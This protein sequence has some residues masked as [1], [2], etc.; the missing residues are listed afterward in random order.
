MG[1]GNIIVRFLF[2]TDSHLSGKVPRHRLDDFPTTMTGKLREVYQTAVEKACDFVAFGGDFFNTHR[3][4]NYD[5]I[6]D[7]M[8]IV[9]E[10]PLK[11]Y[12]CIGE[13]DLYGHNL[14]SYRTSTLRF[15]VRRCP[16][17]EIIRDPI[18]LGEVVLY[19]KHE[20][21]KMEDAIKQEV[22]SSK[23]NILV[24][25]ELI[26]NQ[27][28]MFD[29]ISTASL[30]G[31]PFD[32]VVS[33]DLHDGYDTH[34]ANDTWFVNPGSLAR[35]STAD[36]HRWPQVAIIEI[37]KGIPPMVDIQRLKCALPGDEVLGESIAEVARARED[38]DDKADGFTEEM[39]Q[40]EAESVDVHDLIQKVGRAKGL[41]EVVLNYLATKRAEAA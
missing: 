39:L 24:C 35:R 32:L 7:A 19:S 3:L 40:F 8:D 28:P 21:E 29:I 10:C 37:E 12:A 9:S 27:R 1:E 2:Y 33:G 25:H 31:C 20:P 18:D 17:F 16:Q 15:F 26:T 13:H 5:V 30:K 14:D 22:D 6:G 11:T 23:Y 36:A 38:F 34:E 41:R 4:F